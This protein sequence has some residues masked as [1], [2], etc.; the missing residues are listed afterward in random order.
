MSNK[1]IKKIMT[2]CTPCFCVLFHINQ[3]WLVLHVSVKT[4][5]QITLILN[6][7]KNEVIRVRKG[8][9]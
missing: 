4:S 3:M 7:N 9:R 1:M 8:R 6:I 5:L 2:Q